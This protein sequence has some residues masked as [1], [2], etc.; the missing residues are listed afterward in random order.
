MSIG[1]RA[2]GRQ[3]TQQMGKEKELE[4]KDLNK[5]LGKDEMLKSFSTNK[6]N[7]DLLTFLPFFP[8][9]P[10]APGIPMSP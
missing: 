5:V 1:G 3:S 2:D 8:G 9:T 6:R 10:G 4:R 7:F